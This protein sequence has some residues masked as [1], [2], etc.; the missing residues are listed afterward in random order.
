MY[1][2]F[3]DYYVYLKML[4]Y[5]KK[6]PIVF[7]YKLCEIT[8]K[9]GKEKV[10]RPIAL[11]KIGKKKIQM[12]GLID[13]G[14]DKTVSY[15]Y[16]FGKLLGVLDDIEGE[17]ESI[18]GLFS[19]GSAWPC[20]TDLWIGQYRLNV[21]VYWLTTPYDP[22]ECNY[23]LILGRKIIFNNFDVV[24]CESEGKVYFYKK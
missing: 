23:N 9:N 6:E 8:T 5:S 19:K 10:L 15:A 20:H 11:I 14:S 24:F 2:K 17:P 22:K 1:T 13:S 21:P 12:A 3:K 18:G 7:P 16:P 4:D